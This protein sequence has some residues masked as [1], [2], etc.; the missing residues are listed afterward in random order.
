MEKSF[1]KSQSG[2]MSKTLMTMASGLFL[3][4]L[5]A[6]LTENYLINYLSYPILIIGMVAEVAL[7]FYLSS[8]INKISLASAR[9]WFFVYA[10][11]NGFT[12]STIFLA[13]S[14]ALLS[15]VFLLTAGMFFAASMIGITTK[16]D[17]S[18]MGQFFSMAIIGLF[19]MMLIGMFV[20]SLNFGIAVL[21]ILIFS[22][23]TAYDMQKIKRFHSSAYGINSEDVSKFTIIAALELY[24]DFIN[25]FLFILR[26]INNKR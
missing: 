3:T 9:L 5:I 19:L 17:L 18:V 11:L 6:Y 10:A 22:G 2:F 7:V 16:V 26:L 14:I 1:A 4:F 24:L 15:S 21:G 20:P 8:R 23:L 13:Y 12:L 25:L